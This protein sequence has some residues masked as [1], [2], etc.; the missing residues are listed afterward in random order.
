MDGRDGKCEDP[1]R[2]FEKD[3]WEKRLISLLKKEKSVGDG[4]VDEIKYG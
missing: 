4:S 1:R 3:Y 2:G